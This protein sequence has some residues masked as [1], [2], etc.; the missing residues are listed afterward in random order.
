VEDDDVAALDVPEAVDEPVA[1]TRSFGWMVGA[2]EP[3]G[4]S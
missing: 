3:V 4:I 1:T 2:I